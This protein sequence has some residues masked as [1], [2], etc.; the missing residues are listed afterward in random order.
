[1]VSF[2]ES[3][4][5]CVE[6]TVSLLQ[7]GCSVGIQADV[8]RDQ[9]LQF[10]KVAAF[11]LRGRQAA[12]LVDHA[13]RGNQLGRPVLEMDPGRETGQ[14]LGR[15]R[16]QAACAPKGLPHLVGVQL[17]W[18]QSNSASGDPGSMV[19]TGGKAALSMLKAAAQR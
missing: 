12:R 3:P 14:V 17:E 18:H 16:D 10:V 7:L 11:D 6:E 13:V 1:V 8:L 19:A 9:V 5:R 2:R 4:S 15:L